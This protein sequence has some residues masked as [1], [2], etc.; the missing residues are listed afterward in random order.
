MLFPY[1]IFMDN[2]SPKASSIDLWGRPK[3]ITEP[4]TP[5]YCS[6]KCLSV[7]VMA[8]REKKLK[9]QTACMNFQAYSINIFF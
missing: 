4:S 8:T 1:I 9:G 5:S 3:M 7:T 2:V 6:C